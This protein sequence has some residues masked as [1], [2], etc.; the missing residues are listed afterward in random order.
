MRLIRA[1]PH[2]GL[3]GWEV[4]QRRCSGGSRI[5]DGDDRDNDKQRNKDEGQQHQQRSGCWQLGHFIK[6]IASY[7]LIQALKN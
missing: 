7:C 2:L 3:K 4:E 5:W 1:A 6:N